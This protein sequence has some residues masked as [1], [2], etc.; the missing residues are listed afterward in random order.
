[1]NKIF[2]YAHSGSKNHG[3]EAI[4]RGTVKVTKEESS[5]LTYSVP[6]DKKFGL[7][8]ITNLIQFGPLNMHL[9]EKTKKFQFKNKLKN[10]LKYILPVFLLKKVQDRIFVY[11]LKD[12]PSGINNIYISIGGD[13]YCYNTN[14]KLEY[15][16]RI[17]N[18]L[19]NKTVLWGC[20]IEPDFIMNNNNL[21][22]DLKKYSLITA[23][24]S[25]TYNA[26]INAGIN[27]NT[28]LIPDP[29]FIMDKI[30]PY[31]MPKEFIINNTVGINVSP[32]VEKFVGNNI[33]ISNFENLIS[34]ILNETDMNIALIPH[35]LWD[36]SNDVIPLTKLLYKFN[37][38]HRIF[39]IGNKYN[40]IELKGVIS[41]CRFLVATR[42]HASIAGYSSQVP[43]LVIGYSVKAKGIAKDIFGDYKNYVLPVQDLKN[44]NDI[45]NAFKFL[46]NNE[47]AI[48]DHYKNFMPNYTERVWQATD[49]IKKLQ[50]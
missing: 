39:L 11:L 25:I 9:P 22:E 15:L 16:N 24:E 10:I 50:D 36:N 46:I 6:E 42:T 20:S 30:I 45:T 44:N 5:L 28:H 48:R 3:C 43:T 27:K 26:L 18:K 31:D 37:Y 21:L 1:M 23:R 19:G 32:M 12:I 47:T 34:Y 8:V 38:S 13:N 29:A 40:A 4:V 17:L 14:N 49:L 33:I 2:M 41:Q 35:V 7:D